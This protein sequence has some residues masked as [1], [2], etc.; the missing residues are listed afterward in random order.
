[1]CKADFKPKIRSIFIKNQTNF[2]AFPAHDAANTAH[3][4]F[5]IIDNEVYLI[6]AS[7][8]DLG[9]NGSVSP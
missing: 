5:I 9:K 4:R 3:D 8:K 7:I 6:G 2:I 1:M